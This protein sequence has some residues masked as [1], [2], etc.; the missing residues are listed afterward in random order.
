MKKVKLI[1]A[2]LAA[3]TGI[4]AAVASDRQA[5]SPQITHNWINWNNELVLVNQ[6]QEQ[7]QLVCAGNFGICLRAAD[8]PYIFTVGEL[9]LLH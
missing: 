2:V 7:A 6:T 1:F 4:S 9:M 8:N 5:F 3:V